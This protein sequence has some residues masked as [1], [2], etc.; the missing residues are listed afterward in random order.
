MSKFNFLLEQST[1]NDLPKY[2]FEDVAKILTPSRMKEAHAAFK[3]SCP[4]GPKISHTVTPPEILS[5]KEHMEH[6]SKEIINLRK[7]EK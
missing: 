7:L 1:S 6:I 5:V 3:I 2:Y 4:S